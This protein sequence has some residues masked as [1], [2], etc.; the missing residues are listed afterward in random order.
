MLSHGEHI[1]QEQ[2]L[3]FFLSSITADVWLVILT[4]VTAMSIVLIPLLFRPEL[5]R[6]LKTFARLERG[7]IILCILDFQKGL[8]PNILRAYFIC[9]FSQCFV[10][11]LFLFFLISSNFHFSSLMVRCYHSASISPSFFLLFKEK[12]K[13]REVDI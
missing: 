12:Q 6:K 13:W 5:L 11:F 10:S 3:N 9:F 4:R 2:V 1:Y 7:W 8:I